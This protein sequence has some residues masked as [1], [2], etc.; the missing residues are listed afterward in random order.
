MFSAGLVLL[1]LMSPENA[2]TSLCFFDWVGIDFCPGKG[3]GHSISY[4]F[5]GDFGA[6]FQA[7]LAGP[8][9]VII[10]S[11]RIIYLWKELYQESKLTT[12][13]EPHG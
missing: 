8:A 12:N 6:A 5:R 2:G 4:T 7:H 13:I 1:A 10:L 11:G 3:L 9:S